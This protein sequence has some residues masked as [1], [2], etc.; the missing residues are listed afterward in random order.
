MWK[1]YHWKSAEILPP[2]VIA[3]RRRTMSER[4]FK[5]EFEASFE[6]AG[7]RIYEDYSTA[8]HTTT[9]ILPHEQLCWM[10]DQN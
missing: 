10:H 2:D 3:A 5:Q 1:V 4:Q 9:E 8:N 6:T 7:G